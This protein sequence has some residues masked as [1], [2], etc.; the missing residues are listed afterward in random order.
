MTVGVQLQT[1]ELQKQ[2]SGGAGSVKKMFL[3]NS[4]KIPVPEPP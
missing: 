3:K 1:T 2:S 4:R